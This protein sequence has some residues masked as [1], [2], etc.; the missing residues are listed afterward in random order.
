MKSNISV[1]KHEVIK[2]KC[3]KCGNE[4]YEENIDENEGIGKLCTCLVIW[5]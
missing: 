5:S 4:L 1:G 3:E 2:V